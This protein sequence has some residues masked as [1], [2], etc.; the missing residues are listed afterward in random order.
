MSQ[1]PSSSQE[2]IRDLGQA[3][4]S[5]L[6]SQSEL[7]RISGVAASTIRRAL[8]GGADTRLSTL[9]D[10]AEALNMHIVLVPKAVSKGLPRPGPAPAYVP[11]IVDLALGWK[12]PNNGN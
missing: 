10:L 8:S 1:S 12:E 7:C 6:L 3:F 11:S 2:F 4:A 9:F 5:S